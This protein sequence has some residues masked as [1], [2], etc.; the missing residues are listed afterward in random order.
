MGFLSAIDIHKSYK[1]GET[2]RRVLNGLSLGVQEGDMTLVMGPSGSGKTTLLNILGGIDSADEGRITFDGKDVSS[3]SRGELREYRATRVGFIFQF[4]NLM[5]TLNARDNVELGCEVKD[6]NQERVREESGKYLEK[7]GLNRDMEKF[8]QQLSGGE[9][10][11]VAIARAL[12]KD[13]Q[14]ILGDEPTGNLDE[15]TSTQIIELLRDVNRNLGTT[16]VIVSHDRGLR[17]YADN[18]YELRHGKLSEL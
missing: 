3:F 1:S 18:I 17:E 11:R 10:Q 14:I 9:Q 2:Q 16:M 6:W 12:A 4:Y 13:P 7:V 5:P 15:E 8:P